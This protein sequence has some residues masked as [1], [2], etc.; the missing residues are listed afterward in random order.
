MELYRN[1][2]VKREEFS[3]DKEILDIL[4]PGLERS[5]GDFRINFQ[6]VK[7][8]MEAFDDFRIYGK[9]AGKVACLGNVRG[10][11][12]VVSE[13]I[14]LS[15]KSLEYVDF[16]LIYLMKQEA[17]PAISRN[18]FER[19]VLVSERDLKTL[20]TLGYLAEALKPGVE[21]AFPDLVFDWRSAG[22]AFEDGS[23]HLYG[24][25]IDQDSAFEVKFKSLDSAMEVLNDLSK[26]ESKHSLGF[27]KFPL[28]FTM[29]PEHIKER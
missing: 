12:N 11:W 7:D 5:F 21:A 18:N 27:I 10:I 19:D 6:I 2:C 28:S 3:K 23:C 25:G 22:A 8:N 9:G 20:R 13:L 24:Y 14:D 16:P 17:L 26:I 4:K 1:V 15:R 29:V